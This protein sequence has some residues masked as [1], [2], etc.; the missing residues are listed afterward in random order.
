MFLAQ[1]SHSFLN[2]P[3]S[4]SAHYAKIGYEREAAVEK[5]ELNSIVSFEINDYHPV[6]RLLTVE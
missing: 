3:R 2:L 4:A 5:H 1:N 6:F